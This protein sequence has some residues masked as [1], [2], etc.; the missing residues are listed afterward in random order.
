MLRAICRIPCHHV[1]MAG[2]SDLVEGERTVLILNPHW[3]TGLRPF[4]L[5]VIVAVAASALLIF[6]PHNRLQGPER[7]AVGVVALLAVLIWTALPLL[8]WRTT[9]YE[10]TTRRFRLRYGILSRTGRDFP[11]IRISDVS[12]SHGL[13]D[14]LLGCGRLVV[15]SAGEHGQLVLNEIPHVEKVQATLF[16][17]VEDEQARLARED[18]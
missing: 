13:I 2:V 14:R 12:F 7:I 10:L 9:T 11:L 4:A 18:R 16:Q 15:E 1:H 3:K 8:R 6:I 17:L 5:L